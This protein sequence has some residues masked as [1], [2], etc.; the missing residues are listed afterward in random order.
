M[1]KN[2][3]LRRKN[4]I[5]ILSQSEE[6]IIIGLTGR[7]GAGCSEASKIFDCT[8]KE[9]ELP[10]INPGTKGFSDNSERERRILQRF[11]STHWL[12]FD[13]IKSKSIISTFLLK[14]FDSFIKFLY[15]DQNT[16][17][18][19][20]IVKEW[21]EKCDNEILSFFE[22]DENDNMS[23]ALNNALDNIQITE[24]DKA[25]FKNLSKI[26]SKKETSMERVLQECANA[27][28]TLGKYYENVNKTDFSDLPAKYI[29]NIEFLLTK[30]SKFSKEIIIRNNDSDSLF[31]VLNDLNTSLEKCPLDNKTCLLLNARRIRASYGTYYVTLS[32]LI[33]TFV[34]CCAYRKGT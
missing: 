26:C 28:N 21:K 1:D 7:N 31:K 9:L 34:I 15:N 25:I 8:Y 16:A 18:K 6:F 12:K 23:L 24:S 5:N 19:N 14:D 30:L 20:D 17:T 4:M 10:V 11:A 13:V 3:N 32:G 2:K 29:T 33:K 27:C 22:V